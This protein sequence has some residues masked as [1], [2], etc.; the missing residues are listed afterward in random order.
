VQQGVFIAFE[1]G[2]G[3][4]KSVQIDRLASALRAAGGREVVVTREPG[5]SDL[6]R[7]V[8]RWLLHGGQVEPAAEALLYAADRAQHVA[9]V[10]RPAL[11][12]GAAV[13]TDRYVDSSAAYQG[14]GRGLDEQRVRAVNDFA[15]GGLV[16][17]LTV[18]LDID[19]LTAAARREQAGVA[20]DRLES[21]GLAFHA[22]VNQRYRDFAARD[23][24][25]YAVIDAALPVAHVERLVWAA[26]GPLLGAEAPV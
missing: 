14:W 3:A 21:A 22:E 19:P 1:G 2:D 5:G 15:T 6:G 25:R 11:A 20:A 23:P 26:V 12:R 9:Q 18:L 24:G 17:D 10:I 16:P 7:E 13:L 8:R 4:G